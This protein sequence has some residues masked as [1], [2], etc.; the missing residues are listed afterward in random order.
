MALPSL[1]RLPLT[2]TSAKKEEDE[3]GLTRSLKNTS[4]VPTGACLPRG[5]DPDYC[6][7]DGYYAIGVAVVSAVV[8]ALVDADVPSKILTS[9]YTKASD[10]LGDL[11]HKRPTDAYSVFMGYDKRYRNMD[12][13]EKRL[14]SDNFPTLCYRLNEAM[15]PDLGWDPLEDQ[16]IKT[17]TETRKT[18][19]EERKYDLS[20]IHI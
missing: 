14:A 1:G 2:E 19:D 17:Y 6:A 13:R 20:L 9:M 11:C 10:A 12:D 3:S 5:F 16:G 18:E 7:Y 4:L 8:G 15:K